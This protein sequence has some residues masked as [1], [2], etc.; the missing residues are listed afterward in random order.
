MDDRTLMTVQHP[1]DGRT[2]GFDFYSWRLMRRWTA[3]HLRVFAQG[4]S[5][6][7]A[8]PLYRTAEHLESESL[9]GSDV[10]WLQ[11]FLHI[12]ESASQCTLTHVMAACRQYATAC[13]VPVISTYRL[14]LLK[15]NWSEIR[16]NSTAFCGH[17]DGIPVSA[18]LPQCQDTEIPEYMIVWLTGS[19]CADEPLSLH[20]AA[21]GTY[22]DYAPA[23]WDWMLARRLTLECLS[24]RRTWPQPET[25]PLLLSQKMLPNHVPLS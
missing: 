2:C 21:G 10:E 17:A 20:N 15:P 14:P 25:P 13:E 23:V 8:D 11:D 5:R 12:G 3:D 9:D 24:G 6:N 19:E 22:L 1:I 18:R 16:M 4:A 7:V